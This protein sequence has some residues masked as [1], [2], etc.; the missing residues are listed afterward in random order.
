MGNPT[1]PLEKI[2]TTM[3]SPASFA[4]FVGSLCRLEGYRAGLLK[5]ENVDVPVAHALVI[6]HVVALEKRL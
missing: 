3:L 1:T 4:Y 6:S 2:R 5:T